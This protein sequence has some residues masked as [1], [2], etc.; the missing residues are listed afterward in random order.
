M[1]RSDK[2]LN[3]HSKNT[4]HRSAVKRGIKCRERCNI[5]E[6]N[7]IKKDKHSTSSNNE[8]KHTGSKNHP[9]TLFTLWKPRIQRGGKSLV[10]GNHEPSESH[11]P[12]KGDPGKFNG[13]DHRSQSLYNYR[14][15]L[16]GASATDRCGNEESSYL[17]FLLREVNTS[18]RV[19]PNIKESHANRNS[20]RFLR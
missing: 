7:S 20:Q 14:H 12:L 16:V 17:L 11:R 13:L 8:I 19:T 1:S 9:C 15:S 5:V 2:A 18:W 4:L 6:R 3:S 10:L